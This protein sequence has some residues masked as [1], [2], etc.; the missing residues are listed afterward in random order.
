VGLQLYY[1]NQCRSLQIHLYVTQF[2]YRL[3]QCRV[4]HDLCHQSLHVTSQCLHSALPTH[5]ECH[6]YQ[7]LRPQVQVQVLQICT[8][9]QV[10]VPSTTSLQ[11]E[12]AIIESNTCKFEMLFFGVQYSMRYASF[13]SSHHFTCAPPAE[14]LFLIFFLTSRES[15]LR[16]FFIFAITSFTAKHMIKWHK[17]HQF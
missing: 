1:Q 4:T 9:V 11:S 15:G 3:L 2:L 8:R 12:C 14:P 10:Q 13:D 6:H 5:T 17:W 16:R 7:V